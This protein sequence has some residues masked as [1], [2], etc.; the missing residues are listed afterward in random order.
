MS[1]AKLRGKIREKFK[2]QSC[3]AENMNMNEATLSAKLNKR[4]EWSISEVEKA[5]V[6]LGIPAAE[7]YLYFF[8]PEVAKPQQM[9]E[10]SA[11]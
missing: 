10:R 4:T 5:C 1:Y 7:A 2:T 3:F 8:T 11:V 6:L 9:I